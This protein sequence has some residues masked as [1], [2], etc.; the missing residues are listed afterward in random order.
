M[1]LADSDVS[2]VPIE[3]RFQ[4]LLPIAIPQMVAS[5]KSC[6]KADAARPNVRLNTIV[7][8]LG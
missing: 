2:G 3:A 4:P 5:D 6:P 1:W 8:G 7:T